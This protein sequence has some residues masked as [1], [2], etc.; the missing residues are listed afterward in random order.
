VAATVS[1]TAA[2]CCVFGPRSPYPEAF[3]ARATENVIAAMRTAEVRR[4]VC[5]TGAMAGE[6]PPNVGLAMRLLASIFRRRLPYIAED[7]SEQERSI[8]ASA[9]DWTIVKPPRL[10]DG[11]LTHRVSAD[12]ALRV[13][14]LSRVSRSDL[15]DFLL[16][17]AASWQHLRQRVYVRR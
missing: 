4:L 10:T 12:P 5:V 3:C 16:E 13:G 14:L 15:A 17:E 7:R 8:M 11:P 2:V 9:L 6:L 1:G